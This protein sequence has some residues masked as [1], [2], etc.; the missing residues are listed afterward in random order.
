MKSWILQTAVFGV[1]AIMCALGTYAIAGKY[2][3]DLPCHPED[4][5]EHEVCLSTV[6][7]DWGGDVLWVD[8]RGGK[9]VKPMLKGALVISESNTDEELN[10][11]AQA[12]FKAKLAGKKV[13]V[14]CNSR[15]CGKSAYV[16]KEIVSHHLHD[17]VYI[18][19]G[20]WQAL[21]DRDDLIT[22]P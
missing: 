5:K 16:R 8:A 2:K 6:L 14:F 1:I 7:G 19:Y 9:T 3:R 15:A 17:D 18:L 10:R 11:A 4:L 13:V 22:A 12:L 21:A 20:G